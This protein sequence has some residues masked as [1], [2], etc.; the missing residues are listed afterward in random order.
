[1]AV[2]LVPM[3]RWRG[4]TTRG[5][6]RIP[7]RSGTEA[8][9]RSPSAGTSYQSPARSPPPA[10]FSQAVVFLLA[11]FLSFP[12]LSF[13]I[14][15]FPILSFPILSF[16]ILWFPILS[17]PILPFPILPFPILSFPIQQFFSL[18]SI[19]SFRQFCLTPSFIAPETL[20]NSRYFLFPYF[21]LALAQSS[22]VQYID[23]YS[24]L[25]G[26]F[27]AGKQCT[28]TLVC[29]CTLQPLQYR[30]SMIKS[31]INI[32]IRIEFNLKSK[33]NWIVLLLQESE[34]ML[35]QDT[36]SPCQHG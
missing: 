11:K 14:L 5:R 29:M 28:D 10:L 32:R 25:S 3:R 17:F 35:L 4:V 30:N 27:Q 8:T 9:W 20:S 23:E 21:F 7:S 33:T 22:T 26:I 31:K 2:R 16:P 19:F 12:N 34:L 36:P 18:T 1:M 24:I 6:R 13:P 15:S